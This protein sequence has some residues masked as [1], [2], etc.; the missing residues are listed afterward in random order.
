[1]SDSVAELQQIADRVVAM[2]KPGEHIEAFV[3]RD[4]ETD[5]RI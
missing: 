5:K 2:A 4:A 3:S 1:M